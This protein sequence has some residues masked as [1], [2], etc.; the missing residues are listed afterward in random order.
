MPYGAVTA[1]HRLWPQSSISPP[2]L[3]VMYKL[4]LNDALCAETCRFYGWVPRMITRI[5][6]ERRMTTTWF[7][8]TLLRSSRNIWRHYFAHLAT[9]DVIISLISQHLTDVII[10]LIV[11]GFV[12]RASLRYLVNKANLVHNLFLVY[13]SIP[14]CF[15]PLCAHHQEIQLY[16]CEIWHLL[17]WNKCHI[18]TA[19]SP[20][21]G[22]TV[23]RNM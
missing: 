12:D 8:L 16:L 6:T 10:S 13:L 14:T 17:F 19:V 2:P 20:D 7:R 21:D 3:P 22:H 15:G 9:S 11:L 5:F 18:N 23:G 4:L 1:E